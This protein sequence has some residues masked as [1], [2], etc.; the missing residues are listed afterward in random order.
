MM[1]EGHPTR[2]RK[3]VVTMN[4]RSFNP[5]P[6]ELFKAMDPLFQP[7][8][9]NDHPELPIEI[10]EL[11]IGEDASLTKLAPIV[12]G[13]A[14][15]LGSPTAPAHMDP[16]APW[17]SWVTALWN[18]SLNQNLLHPDVAPVA[19]KLEALIIQWLAP[20][21]KMTGGHMLPG[22]TVANLTALWV[23]RDLKNIKQVVASEAAHLSIPKAAHLL[24]LSFHPI[25][26]DRLGRIDRTKLPTDLSHSA[27]VLTA[28]TTSSGAIDNLS[29]HGCSAWTH[30]D[31]AWAGPLQFSPEHSHRLEGITHADSIAISAHKWLFQPKESGIILFKNTEIAHSAITFEGSYL[32]SPNI[33]LLGSHGAV[34][35]PLLATLLAWGR[36]GLVDRIDRAMNIADCLWTQLNKHPNAYLFGPHMSGVIL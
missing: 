36:S 15:L 12:F 5:E 27:L 10:P 7:P 8:D 17:V 25:S 33:G 30:V 14:A 19:R 9:I 11:G 21:F 31:A 29:L 28:G 22:S 13:H 32:S 26:T 35:L 18:A 23:A 6:K 4:D 2:P 3:K 1:K 24:G 20:F 16:P 34:A